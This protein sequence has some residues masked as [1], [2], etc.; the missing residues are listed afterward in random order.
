LTKTRSA[1][2]VFKNLLGRW[3]TMVFI[4]PGVVTVYLEA[5][6][7]A[8]E[9]YLC[10]NPF[11]N[12]RSITLHS[13]IVPHKYLIFE[14]FVFFKVDSKNFIAEA[15]IVKKMNW[16]RS[17][18]SNYLVY[19]IRLFWSLKNSSLNDIFRKKLQTCVLCTQTIGRYMQ[20]VKTIFL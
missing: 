9:N 16:A 11:A 4:E 3:R 18:H 8:S 13:Y 17:D 1:S 5:F 14:Y 19:C 12:T 20:N 10:N 7:L 2:M 6:I 15:V